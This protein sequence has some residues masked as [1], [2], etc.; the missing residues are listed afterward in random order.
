MKRL[1]FLLFIVCQ[2]CL[3]AQKNTVSGFIEDAQTGERLS[4]ASVF[5]ALSR[6]GTTSNSYGFFS[7]SFTQGDSVHLLFS[8]V[9][10]ETFEK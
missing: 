1:F 8:Y 10:Y 3:F 7:I 9:G 5:D 2:S 4:G 6:T